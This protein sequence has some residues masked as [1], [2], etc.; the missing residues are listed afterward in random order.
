MKY[1]V[2][3]GIGIV[4][5]LAFAGILV[6]ANR[7]EPPC[8]DLLKG[9]Q[10]LGASVSPSF[11]ISNERLRSSEQAGRVQPLCFDDGAL[12]R[13]SG[14]IDEDDSTV[15]VDDRAAGDRVVELAAVAASPNHCYYWLSSPFRVNLAS[16]NS[17]V[18]ATLT[19]L[20][21]VGTAFPTT[22]RVC[23]SPTGGAGNC[24]SNSGWSRSQAFVGPWRNAQFSS[25]GNGCAAAANPPSSIC[26]SA[27]PKYANP[28]S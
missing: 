2:L 21:C 20:Y 6:V 27:G 12:M 13:V 8:T 24:A 22:N 11:R 9:P 15:E 28:P 10:S 7:R 3:L 26:K 5:V 17:V 1:K 4:V 19:P 23:V 16:G 25:T 14:D 18:S